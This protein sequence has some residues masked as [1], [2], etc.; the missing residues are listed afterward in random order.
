MMIVRRGAVAVLAATA[1]AMFALALLA[2]TGQLTLVVTHGVS[3]Q[4]QYH[5]GDLV[6]VA[7]TASYRVDDVVAYRVPSQRMVVLHRLIG[8]DATGYTFKGDNN[9]SVD[10]WHPT[11]DQIVGR[12]VLHLP[13]WGTWLARATHPFAIGMILLILVGSGGTAFERRRRHRRR[14]SGMAAHARQSRAAGSWLLARTSPTWRWAMAITGG[15]VLLWA[16]VA[17]VAWATPQSHQ[18]LTTLHLKRQMDFSYTATVRPSAAYDGTI[19]RSPDPIFRRLTNDLQVQLHYRGPSGDLTVAAKVSSP[20]GWSAQL[21]VHVSA[22]GADRDVRTLTLDLAAIEAKA[23]AAADVTG[24]AT[25]PLT[26]EVEPTVSTAGLAPFSPALRFTLTPLQLSLQGGADTLK[27]AE[28][29][30]TAEQKAQARRL[31]LVGREFDVAKLRVTS[32][33]SLFA[34]ALAALVV[35]LLARR[36]RA[37]DMAALIRCRY[38]SRVIEVTPLRPEHRPIEVTRIGDL[39]GVASDLGLPILR[40]LE[41]GGESFAVQDESVVYVHRTDRSLPS[42]VNA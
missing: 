1:A 12:A 4:P 18:V 16:A 29:V 8:E 23:Q 11:A 26:I 13:Q 14:R 34:F 32:V 31:S 30:D 37:T 5:K 25:S 33:A 3:M 41:H 36:A 40:W 21:P 7:K 35:G 17:A 10:P 19:V 27:V 22:A 38:G 9:E 15:A 20:N 42:G 24:V 28:T 6:V 2:L 39:A